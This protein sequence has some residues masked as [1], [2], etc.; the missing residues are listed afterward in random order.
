VEVFGFEVGQ[1]GQF[2]N[3]FVRTTST[4]DVVAESFDEFEVFELVKSLDL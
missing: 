3:A 4:N 2:V 1:A